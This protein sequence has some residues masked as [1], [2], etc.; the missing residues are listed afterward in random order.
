MQNFATDLRANTDP[1]NVS[2][3]VFCNRNDKL[4]YKTIKKD[5]KAR[6]VAK[7]GRNYSEE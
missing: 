1:Q 2:D 5:I 6:Y 7:Y 3:M 4:L